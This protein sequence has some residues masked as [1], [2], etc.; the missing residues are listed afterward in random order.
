MMRILLRNEQGVVETNLQRIDL[1]TAITA[2]ESLLWLDFYGE[3]SAQVEPILK[4]VF[5]F[6][7]LAID[8]ALHES[9]IPKV[10]DWQEYLYIVLRAINYRSTEYEQL[11][12][13]ELDIFLGPNYIVTFSKESI[14][15]L[16]RAWDSCQKDQRWT[17]RGAGQLLYRLVDDLVGEA[18]MA[19]ENM[20]DELEHIEDILFAEPGPT[21][22]E[23]LFTLKRDVLQVR[24][25]VVPQREVLGKL[26]RN[27]YQ[28]IDVSDRI[29]FRDVYDHLLQLDNLLDDIVILVS[30]ARD[31]YLS[32]INNHMND[33]MKTLTVITAFFMPLAFITGFFGMNFFQAVTPFD[34]WTSRLAFVAVLVATVTIPLVMFFWMRHRSWI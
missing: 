21:T 32:V 20:Q 14:A 11:A 34:A 22:L 19:V 31:T 8:D 17:K 24:R 4:D 5:N 9:H 6:H 2:S 3:S 13:P 33:I 28:C 27:E 15:A 23:R 10:D 18:V 7:P 26:S 29:F 25:I 30:S 12:A 16:D 1:P